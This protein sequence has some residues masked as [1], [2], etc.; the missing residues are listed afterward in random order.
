MRRLRLVAIAVALTLAPPAR[1]DGLERV[2]AL[3]AFGG[4]PWEGKLVAIG[5]GMPWVATL[6]TPMGLFG[7]AELQFWA[8]DP[9]GS[10]WGG[11]ARLGSVHVTQ[12]PQDVQVSADNAY[13]A[14]S[15]VLPCATPPNG[16]I[17][18]VHLYDMRDGTLARD[19]TS[20]CRAIDRPLR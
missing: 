11:A 15:E 19:I 6:K 4:T 16:E 3:R 17:F 2:Q 7:A 14:V 9:S 8:P 5:H 10:S 20:G 1:A 12:N 13:V 18:A